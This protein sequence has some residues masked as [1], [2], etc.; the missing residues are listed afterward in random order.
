MNG[1]VRRKRAGRDG[2]NE[3]N[4]RALLKCRRHQGEKEKKERWRLTPTGKMVI[5]D[6]TGDGAKAWEGVNR[7]NGKR[8]ESE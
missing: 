1:Q 8:A 2:E 7:A 6:R 3:K 4:L 5:F